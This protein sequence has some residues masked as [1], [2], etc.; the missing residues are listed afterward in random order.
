[1]SYANTTVRDGVDESIKREKDLTEFCRQSMDKVNNA[2]GRYLLQYLADYERKHL[3]QLEQFKK[4]IIEEDIFS[5]NRDA[6]SAEDPGKNEEF[7]KSNAHIIRLLKLSTEA[8]KKALEILSKLD[9]HVNDAEWKNE[10]RRLVEKEHLHNRVLYDEFFDIN[11]RDG[12]Y[13]WGD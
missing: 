3:N 12:V 8:E 5:S 10:F 11:N 9:S 4:K 6:S 13:H 7:A 2:R 1:M